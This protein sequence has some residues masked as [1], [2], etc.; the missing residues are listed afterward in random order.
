MRKV[1]LLFSLLVALALVVVPAIAA[2]PVHKVTYSGQGITV[3]RESAI[4]DII[5][6]HV[7][8]SGVATQAIADPQ[9]D[10]IW[11]GQGSF[12]DKDKGLKAQLVVDH[13]TYCWGDFILNGN[14]E[15]TVDKVKVGTYPFDLRLE[16]SDTGVPV[17]YELRI[18]FS[19]SP[20]I[21]WFVVNGIKGNQIVIKSF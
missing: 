5:G 9:V 10:G 16:L 13:G 7:Y 1:L 15:V 19:G 2:P 21:D 20:S 3:D 12:M 18:L 4:D 14:A 17:S 11:K 6:N 8:F